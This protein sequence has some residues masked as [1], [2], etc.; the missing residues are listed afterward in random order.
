M[1]HYSPSCLPDGSACH[2][3]VLDGCEHM[4]DVF[5][6]VRRLHMSICVQSI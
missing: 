2:Y 5:T 3:H 1:Y 4:L 6:I